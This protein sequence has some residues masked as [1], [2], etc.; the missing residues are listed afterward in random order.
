MTQPKK[1]VR[2]RRTIPGFA[3]ELSGIGN[4]RLEFLN[5]FRSERRSQNRPIP[6]RDEFRLDTL[7]PAVGNIPVDIRMQTEFNRIAQKRAVRGGH[8]LE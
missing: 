6:T 1:N 7:L 3:N 5:A 2:N 8:H 4:Q